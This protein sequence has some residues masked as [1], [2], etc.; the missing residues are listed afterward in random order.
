[1]QHSGPSQGEGIPPNRVSRT[2]LVQLTPQWA[3]FIASKEEN[4]FGADTAAEM[5]IDMPVMYDLTGTKTFKVGCSTSTGR[6][7][8]ATTLPALRVLAHLPRPP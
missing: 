1:M 6:T 8:S 3:D 2:R 7:S 5:N 4:E